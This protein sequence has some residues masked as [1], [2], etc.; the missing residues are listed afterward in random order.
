MLLVFIAGIQ[1]DHETPS[2]KQLPSEFSSK[3]DAISQDITRFLESIVD[4]ESPEQDPYPVPV[5]ELNGK[6]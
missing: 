3:Y 4:A 2:P 6:R 1:I 5:V